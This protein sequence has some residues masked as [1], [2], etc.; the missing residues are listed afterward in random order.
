MKYFIRK[1]LVREAI[2]NFGKLGYRR[3]TFSL[4]TNSEKVL[5]EANKGKRWKF[6]E[7]CDKTII[8]AIRHQ[9]TDVVV[10]RGVLDD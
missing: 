3:H 10:D 7:T 6:Y 4:K 1:V 8:K 5:A 9:K 2:N